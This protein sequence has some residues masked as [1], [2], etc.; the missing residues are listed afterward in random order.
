MIKYLK[1]SEVRRR[2]GGVSAMAIW[3]WRRKCGFPHPLRI[4]RDNLYSV[5]DLD[6]FDVARAPKTAGKVKE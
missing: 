5:T 2:Y 4:G 6:A 3:R 1:E